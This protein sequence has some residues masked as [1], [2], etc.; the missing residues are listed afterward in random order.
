MIEFTRDDLASAD[1]VRHLDARVA[2]R[3]SSAA[4]VEGDVHCGIGGPELAG[5]GLRDRPTQVE[6][7]ILMR[8]E[9]DT[10]PI[11]GE[12]SYTARCASGLKSTT[13]CTAFT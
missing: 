9:S 13:R 6:R 11:A 3:S 12:S 1:P 2:D 4:S 7:F 8:V 5:A 10:V